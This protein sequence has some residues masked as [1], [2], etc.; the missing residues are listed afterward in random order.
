MRNDRL[1]VEECPSEAAGAPQ[2]DAQAAAAA[3][4]LMLMPNQILLPLESKA[5]FA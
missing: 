3:K 5:A 4:T 1:E 2:P